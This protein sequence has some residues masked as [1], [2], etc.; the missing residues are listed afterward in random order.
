MDAVK[1]GELAER[2]AAFTGFERSAVSVVKAAI[3]IVRFVD[4]PAI[5]NSGGMGLDFGGAVG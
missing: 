5:R 2:C 4:S 1:A 3:I